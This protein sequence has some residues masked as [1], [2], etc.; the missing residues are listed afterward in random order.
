MLIRFGGSDQLIP[1]EV[2]ICTPLHDI[3]AR[4]IRCLIDNLRDVID[5]RR[6]IAILLDHLKIADL[7]CLCHCYV[8]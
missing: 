1:C 3:A 7:C 4:L 2:P 8:L 5:S 6:V